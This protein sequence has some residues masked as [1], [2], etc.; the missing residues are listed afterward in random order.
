MTTPESPSETPSETD[1]RAESAPRPRCSRGAATE[2]HQPAA[3]AAARRAVPRGREHRGDRRDPRRHAHRERRPAGGRPARRGADRGRGRAGGPRRATG[4]EGQEGLHAV[5][6][7]PHKGEP[8]QGSAKAA[9]ERAFQ[10]A[11]AKEQPGYVRGKDGWLFFTDYQATNFSQAL[12]RVTQTAEAGASPGSTSGRSRPR[13]SRTAGG[14]YYVVV[15]AGQLGRLPAEAADLGPAAARHHLAREADGRPP[16]AALDRHAQAAAEGGQEARHLRAAQQPLDAV[17]RLRGLAGDH[18]VPAG[19]QPRRSAGV[20]AP[21]DHRGR[22]RR[23][24]PTSSP[25]T[26]CPTASRAAPSRSTPQPHPATTTTHLPD[27]APIATSPDD[28]STDTCMPAQDVDAG[29][30]EP[31]LTLLALR[32][33]TGNALS[34]LYSWSFGT[35]VQYGHGIGQLPRS[36]RPNLADADGDLPP[37]RGALRHHRAVPVPRPEP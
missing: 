7:P 25:A 23:P 26:A 24:T 3:A 9:S 16:R 20:D 36:T 27:G 21:A 10:K 4:R 1:R 12:G 33:S 15:I 28:S 30:P 14:K 5:V 2:A 11:I 6:Q 31:E 13:R 29:R 17:R 34:P 18:Q 8:W 37:R 19:R 22:H 32:D 35:T